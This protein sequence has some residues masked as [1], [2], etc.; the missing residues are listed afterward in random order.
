MMQ[1]I[2]ILP[3]GWQGHDYLIYTSVRNKCQVSVINLS[4]PRAPIQYKD[5]ILTV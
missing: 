4:Q 5:D 1:M 2:K 3:H